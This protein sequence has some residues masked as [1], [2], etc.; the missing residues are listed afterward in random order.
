MKPTLRLLRLR[1]IPVDAHW[2]WPVAFAVVAW[3]LAASVFPSAYPDVG[4]LGHV[5]MAIV[6]TGILLGSVVL[7]ELA[8]A[9]VA[10]REGME[11]EGVCLWLLGGVSDVGG[12][13][14]SP[15]QEFRIAASGPAVSL[16]LAAVLAAAGAW[17][18][19]RGWPD[20]VHGVLEY[21]ARLNVVV[22]AFNLIPALPLDGGRI[23]RSW[24]WHRQHDLLAA[25]R[26]GARAGQAFGLTL[27]V[28]GVLDVLSGATLLGVWLAVLGGFLLRAA[29]S[30][31]AEAR[32][33]HRLDG[34][35]AADVMAS[36]PGVVL[37]DTPVSR[38]VQHP[39]APVRTGYPVL[40]GGRLL[41]VIV[42]DNARRVPSDE[43][44]QRPVE[45]VMTPLDDVPMVDADAAVV[46]VVDRL[47][48]T[49]ATGQV[50]V[51]ADGMVVGILDEADVAGALDRAPGTAGARAVG[52]RAWAVVAGLCVLAGAAL[53][54]PPYAIVSAGPQVDVTAD[55]SL[56]GITV[57]PVNGRYVVPTVTYRRSNAI[58]TVLAGVRGGERVVPAS[59][60]DDQAD[61]GAGAG[62]GGPGLSREARILA[63]AAAA[64]SQNLSATVTGTGARV[65]AVRPGSAAAG[66]LRPGDVILAV[67]SR[68]VSQ[69][70]LLAE[71]VRA[72]APGT[73]LSLS[74]ERGGRVEVIPV[75]IAADGLG[76]TVETRDLA[77]ELPFEVRFEGRA[78]GG[79]GAGLAYALAIADLLSSTDVAQGRTIAAAGAVDADGHV[80]PVDGLADPAAL[81]A[82]AADAGA[83]VLVVPPEVADGARRDGLAV[84][85][86]ESLARALEAL[87]TTV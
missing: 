3:T 67:D 28:V 13:P 6:A 79:P 37:N 58:A 1:G 34:L 54:R 12:R 2:T 24:L 59:R 15:G 30:E 4:G 61:A 11:V 60:A 18:E 32:T 56:A 40:G 10:R 31:L 53:Y 29:S 63:A 66:V 48:G 9:V 52:V 70:A 33:R 75:T 49:N 65:A 78:A 26:S 8:H 77:V 87:S 23:L 42:L 62:G 72:G 5:V 21:A 14:S 19:G 80:V 85:G 51:V 57:T 86:V 44:D 83:A 74:V 69:S 68:P 45:D 38:L 47:N 50:V 16:I 55:V 22:A 84:Q 36:N 25:T 71:V 46:D 17:G 27:V 81:A 43:A 76:L 20:P 82:A 41:G 39:P 35:T 7:H 64:L 73:L